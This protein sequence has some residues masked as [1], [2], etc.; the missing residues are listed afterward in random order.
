MP[1]EPKAKVTPDAGSAP[2]RLSPTVI[3]VPAKRTA[4]ARDVAPVG[5]AP[6]PTVTAPT[7]I[8][9]V[10]R[11]R[12]A[13]SGA[14]IARLSPGI[15]PRVARRAVRFIDGFVLEDAHDEQAAQW[16]HAAQLRYAALVSNAPPPA[17]AEILDPIRGY[18]GRIVAILGAID[19]EAIHAPRRPPLLGVMEP[20]SE[21][22]DTPRR[23][24]AARTE[25]TRLQHLSRNALAPLSAIH[26]AL[27]DHA[28]RLEALRLE[29]EAAAVAA[30]F[31]SEHLAIA[32]PELSRRFLQR[33]MSLTQT[34]VEI[35]SGQ[36]QRNCDVEEA[37]GLI[38]ALQDVVLVDLVDWLGET[39]AL[40]DR[41]RLTATDT[42]TLQLRLRAILRNLEL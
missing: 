10:A 27:D 18:L 42:G 28:R 36:F 2:K 39:A 16:G 25:L 30:L 22:I 1:D 37:R 26:G 29:I 17:R 9:G 40:I 14:D 15:A 3:A 20:A 33:E 11:K 4:R 19:I 5:S 34:L 13:I 31:L 24:K 7:A 12:I 41:R 38:K 32:R 21:R 23:L 6:T 8:P 35:R